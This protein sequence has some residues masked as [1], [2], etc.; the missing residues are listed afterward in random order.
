MSNSLVTLFFHLLF[1]CSA[2]IVC[3]SYSRVLLPSFFF[4]FFTCFSV[5]DCHQRKHRVMARPSET[6]PAARNLRRWPSPQPLPH[7]RWSRDRGRHHSQFDP[8]ELSKRQTLYVWGGVSSFFFAMSRCN[9]V[10]ILL[11]RNPIH[12]AIILLVNRPFAGQGH[13]TMSIVKIGVSTKW[14]PEMRRACRVTLLI[15]RP[16]LC[17]ILWKFEKFK[18]F[19]WL[20]GHTNP[21]NFSNFQNWTACGP[22]IGEANFRRDDFRRDFLDDIFPSFSPLHKFAL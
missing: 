7:L 16:L 19:V 20:G 21:L 14:L 5:F 17:A 9:V 4:H 10:I 18:G 1:E 15:F 11:A 22:I 3:N 8:P 2:E 12:A 13:V 6:L